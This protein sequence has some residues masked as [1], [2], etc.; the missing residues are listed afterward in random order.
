MNG[1]VK[2]SHTNYSFP[3]G[4]TLTEDAHRLALVLTKPDFLVSVEN[5]II[6]KQITLRRL[7]NH[8]GRAVSLAEVLMDS[9]LSG[10]ALGGGTCPVF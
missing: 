2:P 9:S 1:H 6:S 4:I 8:L 10:K 5:Y 3:A 7:L